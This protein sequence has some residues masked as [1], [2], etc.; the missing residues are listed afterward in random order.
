VALAYVDGQVRN[1]LSVAPILAQRP[2]PQGAASTGDGFIGGV[3][4]DRPS[5]TGE[6]FCGIGPVEWIGVGLGCRGGQYRVASGD[7]GIHGAQMR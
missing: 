2:G 6:K 4:H 1:P 7:R 5:A 3:F